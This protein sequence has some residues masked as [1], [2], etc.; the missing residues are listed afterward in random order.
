MISV[1][2][3]SRMEDKRNQI[4]KETYTKIYEQIS[5]KIRR[6]VDARGKRT[7]AE[8]PSFLV[9]YP[10]FDKYKAAK[11]L[12]RQLENNGFIV[13]ITGDVMLDIS[14]EVKKVVRK[15]QEVE[16]DFPT[17]INLRKAA[18]KYRGYAGN[19]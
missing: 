4:K 12:K 15:P 6:T 1:D 9:G 13:V 14:W 5:R 16:N 11:Y 19:G 2:E 18:N 7:I 8:V 3:I 10:S 17:L